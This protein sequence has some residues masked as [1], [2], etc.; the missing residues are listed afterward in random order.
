M[1]TAHGSWCSSASIEPP[2]AFTR[3]SRRSRVGFGSTWLKVSAS[4]PYPM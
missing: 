3:V 1:L 4:S 2:L